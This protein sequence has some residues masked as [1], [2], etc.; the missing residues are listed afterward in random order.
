MTNTYS[1]GLGASFHG[2]GA[3]SKTGAYLIEDKVRKLTPRECARV[4]GF[5]ETFKIPVTESQAYKQFGNSVVIPVIKS[6]FEQIQ[7]RLTI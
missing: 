2:G 4:M 6:V 1:S 5:P 7:K 3:A